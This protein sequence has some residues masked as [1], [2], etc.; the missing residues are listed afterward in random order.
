MV[1]LRAREC[2]FLTKSNRNGEKEVCLVYLPRVVLQHRLRN[3]GSRQDLA[4]SVRSQAGVVGNVIAPDIFEA[5]ALH[6]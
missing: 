2:W 6:T 1:W 4:I 5:Y 3:I